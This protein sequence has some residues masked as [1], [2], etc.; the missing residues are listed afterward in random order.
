MEKG[1]DFRFVIDEGFDE[2][3]CLTI[4]T[5]EFMP[6]RGVE[7]ERQNQPTRRHCEAMS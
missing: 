3:F 7:S 6:F 5:I 2:N 1:K 4:A